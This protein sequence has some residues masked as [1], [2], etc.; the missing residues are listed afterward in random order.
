MPYEFD[1]PRAIEHLG[2]QFERALPVLFLGAGFSL[3]ASNLDGTSSI[4]SVE[5]LKKQLWALC[6]PGEDYAPST[7]LQNLFESSLRLHRNDASEMLRRLL[8]VNSDTLPDWYESYF[9]F[10]WA[11][12]Y[13]L[14]IDD[15]PRAASRKFGLPRALNLISA[16]RDPLEQSQ[17]NGRPHLDVVHLNGDIDGIP[18]F[19][20]FSTTQYAERLARPEPWYLR[21][22]SDLVSRPFVFVESEVAHQA[23]E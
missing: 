20:T 7:S 18:D 16:L 5:Q 15:L 2:S 9:A 23:I 6:F 11:R 14:N 3:A 4:P 19:V 12:T 22:V 21:L 10:P 17:S 13:T 8:T 1:L